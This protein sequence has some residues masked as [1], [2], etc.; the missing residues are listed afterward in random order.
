MTF[1]PSQE[2]IIKIH[3]ESLHANKTSY[4][5]TVVFTKEFI[6]P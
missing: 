1:S 5:I 4:K 2:Q 3:S 6:N